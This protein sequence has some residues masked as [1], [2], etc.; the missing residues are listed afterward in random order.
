[1]VYL[2]ILWPFL[3]ELSTELAQAPEVPLMGI[4]WRGLPVCSH[5]SRS[6]NVPSSV[7]HNS[8]KK[9]SEWPPVGGWRNKCVSTQWTMT[10][11]KKSMTY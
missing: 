10:Q 2:K 3:K 9:Q 4:Y 8:R 1:M 5:K 7:I 6:V 11:P